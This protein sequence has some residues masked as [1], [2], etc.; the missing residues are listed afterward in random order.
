MLI[1]TLFRSSIDAHPITFACEQKNKTN[2][3]KKNNSI[4]VICKN[5]QEVHNER[6]DRYNL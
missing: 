2:V 1:L 3:E 6:T 5:V 4:T